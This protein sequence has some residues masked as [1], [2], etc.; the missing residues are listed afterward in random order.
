MVTIESAD[1]LG[2][3]IITRL[4]LWCEIQRL[5]EGG[6]ADGRATLVSVTA[7]ISH[8]HAETY[9]MMAIPYEHDVLPRAT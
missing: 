4:A 7:A 8:Y 1:I 5:V 6:L 9:P 2:S 3:L